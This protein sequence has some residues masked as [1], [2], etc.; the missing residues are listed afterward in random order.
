MKIKTYL[1]S[2]ILILGAF[3]AKAQDINITEE[4]KISRMMELYTSGNRVVTSNSS[5]DGFRVQL[6]ATTDRRKIE[7]IQGK[8]SARYPGVYVGW[9]QAAPYYK[10]RAGGFQSRADAQRFM[11]KIKADF[12][13]AFVI[14]ERVKTSEITQDQ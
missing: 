6:L 5:F 7:E 10:V 1:L 14:P 12:P 3:A 9:T 4:P 11:L 8:F 13:D 2:Y